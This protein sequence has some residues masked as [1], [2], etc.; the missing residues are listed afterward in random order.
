LVEEVLNK[1]AQQNRDECDRKAQQHYFLNA[2]FA[3]EKK[4]Q[5]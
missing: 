1:S 2:G 4:E 3:W 5:D